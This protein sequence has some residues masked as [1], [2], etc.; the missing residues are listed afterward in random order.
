MNSSW[1]KVIQGLA[2]QTLSLSIAAQ[3]SVTTHHNDT[4]RTGQNL[5]ETILN[6]SNVNVNTFGKLFSRNVGRTDLCPAPIC[7]RI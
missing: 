4:N 5:Q 6:T 3:V 7:P 2:L 1:T